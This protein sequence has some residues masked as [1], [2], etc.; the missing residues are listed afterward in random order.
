SALEEIAVDL[1]AERA[2]DE[3]ERAAA[4]KPYISGA[5]SHWFGWFRRMSIGRKIQFFYMSNLAFALVA[6]LFVIG[7]YIHLGDRAEQIA[8]EH[9]Y[10]LDGERLVAVM[11]EAQRHAEMLVATGETIRTDAALER[12]EVAEDKVAELRQKVVG[13][14][15]TALDRLGLIDGGIADFRRQVRAFDP[16][17]SNALRRA[18]QASE[19]QATGSLTLEA[20]RELAERL[21]TKAKAMSDAGAALISTLLVAWIGFAMVLTMLT[22]LATRFFD[23]NVGGPIKGMTRE[24]KKLASG[25]ND[26]HISGRTREDEIGDMARAMQIFH[27]AGKRLERLGRERAEKAKAELEHST[28]LQVQQEEARLERERMLSD[29]ANQFERTVGDVVSTVAEAS[30]QLQTTSQMMAQ[31][32]E[33]SSRRAG[34][35]S[36]SMADANSGATAAAAASD[37]FAMS[38]GEISRQA[39][40]SADLARKA[41][42]SATK[43]DETISAL[44]DSAQ[45]VGQI[46]ELIQT[47][48]HRT[49]LLALNASIEAARGGEAGRGFAV[50][51]SEVKELA[52]QTSRATEQ[53][54]E[55]IRA[56]QDTTGAS[57]TALRSIAGQVKELESTAVSIA[58]A[59]DQQSVAGQDLAR[60]IDL[61]AN[62]T[63]AVAS[64]IDDVREL[65]LST[66]AAAGQVLTSA[67]DLDQQAATLNAQVQAFLAKVRAS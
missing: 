26:V 10:A 39:A 50:V 35:V 16:D 12:L 23:Q 29:V 37:E 52:M 11:S 63:Q 40:S 25:D 44:S 20:A 1:A 43:A 58:S 34:E 33:E 22:L 56:M 3:A 30:T 38:I 62:G 54:A 21:N 8:A 6:G 60:S 55:Q 4:R 31:T 32:A 45:Q 2:A 46:V 67:N 51:A 9:D 64:H 13:E 41:T 49:N 7:G 36:A 59:V 24:M 27:R 48:A 14:D 17:G 18:S 19:I 65:S 28:R 53:V 66:G 61:A 42:D 57:V 47:I 5:A 15:M